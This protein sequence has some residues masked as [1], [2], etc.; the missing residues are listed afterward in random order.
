MWLNPVY[1]NPGARE[2]LRPLLRP[3]RTLGI[4]A[5]NALL[6]LG[7]MRG[8]TML[9]QSVPAL[10]FATVMLALAGF[11][12]WQ[13]HKR[14]RQGVEV[15]PV[16]ILGFFLILL[17]LM[18]FARSAADSTGFPT[19]YEYVIDIDRALFGVVP[20]VW[21]QDHLYT[22]GSVNVFDAFSFVTYFSYFIMPAVLGIVLWQI[23]AKGFR[24]Y[25]AALI[26]MIV[27]GTITFVTLPTAPPWLAAQDG[28]LPE[29]YRIGPELLNLIQPGAYERGY[30]AVGV[31]DVAAFP[32]YH[33]AQTTL[34]AAAI[35]WYMPRLRVLGV[36]YVAS[37]CFA[38]TY[39]GEHYVSDELAGIVVAVAAWTF[40]LRV[41]PK[42]VGHATS[43]PSPILESQPIEERRA[44]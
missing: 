1:E 13:I 42:A 7:A 29:V 21:L 16:L 40:A 32:S 27:C 39:M 19:R 14:D 35:W 38:L 33:T 10:L 15:K 9:S 26:F 31:N 2:R 22:P 3:L 5:R 25:M 8:A 17:A 36:L 6:I 20:T 12:Y 11:V 34:M 24:V 23:N 37:M 18:G 44:A 43:I 30:Q 4:V 41:T 28:Y